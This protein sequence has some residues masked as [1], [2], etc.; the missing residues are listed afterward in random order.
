MLGLFPEFKFAVFALG[1]EESTPFSFSYTNFDVHELEFL[2]GEAPRTPSSTCDSSTHGKMY[3]KFLHN[4]H[5]RRKGQWWL[6]GYNCAHGKTT[7]AVS[8][9]KGCATITEHSVQSVQVPE[10]RQP[11]LVDT[12][13][14]AELDFAG[15][16]SLFNEYESTP[17]DENVLEVPLPAPCTTVTTAAV[18][19]PTPSNGVE[20]RE[21]TSMDMQQ[22]QQTLETWETFID[23]NLLDVDA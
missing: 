21:C 4:T 2:S 22:L 17:P 9:E 8:P 18:P 14:S 7:R 5:V 10:C 1:I 20:N 13:S 23:W 12:E 3:M 11:I 15:I 16:C 6:P 19:F